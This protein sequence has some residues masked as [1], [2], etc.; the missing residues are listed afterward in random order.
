[1]QMGKNIR[2]ETKAQGEAG[3]R[4]VAAL[5]GKARCGGACIAETIMRIKSLEPADIRQMKKSDY[6]SP[7][8]ERWLLKCYQEAGKEMFQLMAKLPGSGE[9]ERQG[10]LRE[11]TDLDR[12][13]NAAAN[14]ILTTNQNL[15]H[16]LARRAKKWLAIEHL[17]VED[18]VQECNVQ[19]QS[20]AM[21]MFDTERG[22]R[23]TTYASWWILHAIRRIFDNME[24]GIR[25]PVHTMDASRRVGFLM[26]EAKT[27]DGK[28][29][30]D[31]EIAKASGLSV[32]SIERVRHLAGL[33][34]QS[35]IH[36][37]VNVRGED[38]SSP[39]RF[40]DNLADNDAGTPERLA[41]LDE[42]KRLVSKLLMILKPK[43]LRIIKMRFGI[44]EDRDGMTLDDIGQ[45]LNL[46]RE[47]IRQIQD[48]ALLKLRKRLYVA[49]P[50]AE[51]AF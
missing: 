2:Y 25:L 42:Q 22:I 40:I 37:K 51:S 4:G 47:R 8:D 32:K 18:L 39:T 14:V 48:R 16:H 41:A 43:E 3:M 29:L 34:R 23:F 9:E 5:D 27:R 35:S 50:L 15:V 26:R 17:S 21:E 10:I 33:R 20:K 31:E 36:E 45:V 1:M 49:D 38:D 44:G 7:F 19:L 24:G 13:R 11:I 28:D 30:D 6:L 12:I 46:S